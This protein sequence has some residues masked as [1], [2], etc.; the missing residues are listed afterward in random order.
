LIFICW[1][2]F[3]RDSNCLNI[4]LLF[5]TT[6]S[7]FTEWPWL[8]DIESKFPKSKSRL[9]KRD[10][11]KQKK[12]HTAGS[13]G[14]KTREI[15]N[16]IHDKAECNGLREFDFATGSQSQPTEIILQIS[17]TLMTTRTVIESIWQ[18]RDRST[19]DCQQWSCIILS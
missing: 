9:C 6:N 2:S 1:L 14:W 19:I 5:N 7:F 13:F 15:V 10:N 11:D 4:Q 8:V 17:D 12:I 16:V 18:I 3:S